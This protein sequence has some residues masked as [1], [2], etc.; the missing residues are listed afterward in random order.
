MSSLILTTMSPTINPDGVDF[1]TDNNLQ[2]NLLAGAMMLFAPLV[3]CYGQRAFKATLTI[4][5]AIAGGFGSY[6]L[7]KHFKPHMHHGPA[8]AII[9]VSALA[10]A[11]ILLALFRW[12]E[13]I[14]GGAAGLLVTTL[15]YS[16][17]A[18]HFGYHSTVVHACALAGGT[19]LGCVLGHLL[20]KEAL[21]LATALIGSFMAIS[22][23]NHFLVV[24]KA[25]KHAPLDIGQLLR[26]PT[27]GHSYQVLARC[28]NATCYGM[29]G[30][31]AVL[32][33]F[34]AWFQFKFVSEEEQRKK[35]NIQYTSGHFV[36]F[37][38]P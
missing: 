23:L 20:V 5:G 37:Q 32:F 1:F 7:L 22:A 14:I 11:L 16:Q 8:L 26:A 30:G 4:I 19:L 3:L 24:L 13:I 21:R 6:F 10:A 33:L 15:S 25:T 34:G 2:A 31:W 9:G 29:L 12:M 38:N 36:E 28:T 35:N 18:A 17:I 27:H